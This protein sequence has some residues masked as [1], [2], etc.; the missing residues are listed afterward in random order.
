MTVTNLDIWIRIKVDY[1]GPEGCLNVSAFNNI[2]KSFGK[3]DE[4]I[5]TNKAENKVLVS[6]GKISTILEVL[7]FEDLPLLNDLGKDQQ[8]FALDL[9]PFKEILDKSTRYTA[10]YD[11]ASLFS[12]SGGIYLSANNHQLYSCATDGSRLIS[13]S[14]SGF[15]EGVNFE[16][17]IPASA[18]EYILSL[19][20]NSNNA[21]FTWSD[22]HLTIKT[23]DITFVTR[24]IT[25]TYPECKKL[26]PAKEG[27]DMLLVNRKD[28]LSCLKRLLPI[29]D[30]R[31][32]LVELRI[33]G[34][35]LTIATGEG[36]NT[37]ETLPI[38]FKG[39][40]IDIRLNIRFLIDLLETLDQD[41]AIL[42][43]KGALK[44]VVARE[45]NFSH[46]IVPVKS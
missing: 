18:S 14:K 5:I 37:L 25:G 23:E 29:V 12:V 1:S 15:D 16:G 20:K 22:S 34:E 19:F 6:N 9:N 2:V 7:D 36:I 30:K 46:L 43:I 33:A 17:V 10:G 4:I 32:H 26:I 8:T 40:N 21:N 41:Q 13:S 28:L 42:E 27:A 39:A 24:L 44:P 31:T 38:G 3:N 35:N 45:G 11:V